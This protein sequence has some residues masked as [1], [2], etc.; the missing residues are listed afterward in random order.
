MTR[1]SKFVLLNCRFLSWEQYFSCAS[2]QATPQSCLLLLNNPSLKI[3]ST[4]HLWCPCSLSTLLFSP[5]PFPL[6]GSQALS[7]CP[8]QE[9]YFGQLLP[10]ISFWLPLLV[11]T[12]D[13]CSPPEPP[14]A[15]V[16]VLSQ[17]LCSLIDFSKCLIMQL[18]SIAI[19]IISSLLQACHPAGD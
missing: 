5:H 17:L 18:I 16:V 8:Q 1:V 19:P 14:C 15:A 11:K 10:S 7:L 9:E 2:H 4:N 13:S 6:N 3:C 12:Q